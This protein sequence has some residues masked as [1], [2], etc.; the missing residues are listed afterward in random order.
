MHNMGNT[1]FMSSVLQTLVHNRFLQ[2]VFLS[3]SEVRAPPATPC[4]H[5][6]LHEHLPRTA[7]H[8]VARCFADLITPPTSKPPCTRAQWSNARTMVVASPRAG[9]SNSD[10]G[11]GTGGGGDRQLTSGASNAASLREDFARLFAAMF[12]V[13]AA[14]TAEM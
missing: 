13:S 14:A 7:E 6:C 11:G 3:D 8:R 2:T 4:P 1:C 5:P 9:S 10:N 12:S